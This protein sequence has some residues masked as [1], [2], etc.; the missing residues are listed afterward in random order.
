MMANHYE[1]PDPDETAREPKPI[2]GS[3]DAESSEPPGAPSPCPD[4][5]GSG[6]I[7]L[8]VSSCPC[9]AMPELL[10]SGAVCPELIFRFRQTFTIYDEQKRPIQQT[11][12]YPPGI[13]GGVVDV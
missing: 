12:I 10:G 8:L 13:T 9:E 4:C 11:I 6:T 7:L 2:D 5:K 1:Y 3:A